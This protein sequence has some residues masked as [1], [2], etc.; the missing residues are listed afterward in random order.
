AGGFT[1]GVR[2][3]A[4]A[5]VKAGTHHATVSDG[6][7]ISTDTNDV[8]VGAGPPFR[9]TIAAQNGATTAGTAEGFTARLLDF[10]GNPCDGYRGTISLSASDARAVLPPSVTYQPTDAGSHVFFAQLLT[11]GSQ[12]ITATDT[13]NA[14]IACNASLTITPAAPKIALAIP[15]N[16]NAGY[17]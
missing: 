1:S 10:Y 15:G 6:T 11:A 4:L 14:A 17:P 8:S 2:T 12:T 9:I 16:A 3:V 5:F 7:S 13:A